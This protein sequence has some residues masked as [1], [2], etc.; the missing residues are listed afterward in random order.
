MDNIPPISQRFRGFLPVVIDVETGGFNHKKD[1]LLELA[2]VTL[3]MDE[4]G[5]LQPKEQFD[6]AIRPFEGA[7]LEESAL[8]F[9]GIDPFCPDR[10]AVSE[11]EAL[12]QLFKG[13]RKEMKLQNCTRAILVGHNAS[14]D[15]NFLFAAIE[16]CEIKR[17]PFHPFSTFDTVTLSGLAFGQTVL[18]TACGAAGIS[19]DSKQAHSALYD[20][21]RTAELF[22]Y[23]VNKWQMLGGWNP[24]EEEFE[25]Y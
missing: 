21:L 20:T 12:N 15:H 1:A 3:G 10:K 23:I 22:C 6:Y 7:N 9:T 11:S 13:L 24:P 5:K 25:E 4:F 18:A 19:F 14:F 8:K 16:R 2:A 17:A